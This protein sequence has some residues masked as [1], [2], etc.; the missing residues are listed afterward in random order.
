MQYS[1]K[2]MPHAA[3]ITV[4]SGVCLKRRWPYHASVMNTLDAVSSRIGVT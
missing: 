2:A 1:I 4:T 3:K